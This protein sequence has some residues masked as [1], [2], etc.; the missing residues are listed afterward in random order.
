M[1][2]ISSAPLH[3]RQEPLLEA[4][5][6]NGTSTASTE[7]P[8]RAVSAVILSGCKARWSDISWGFFVVD[9][10]EIW[11]SPPKRGK[12]TMNETK[13]NLLLPLLLFLIYLLLQLVAFPVPKWAARVLERTRSERKR[14]N[15]F[16]LTESRV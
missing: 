13:V 4:R 1:T 10:P 11:K 3:F 16:K 12:Q 9:N 8:G 5:I 15:C 6:H 14:E 7:P 2:L